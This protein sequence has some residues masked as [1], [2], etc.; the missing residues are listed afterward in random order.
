MKGPIDL[1][2]LKQLMDKYEVVSVVISARVSEL[3]LAG[4]PTVLEK[5]L[6]KGNKWL[7]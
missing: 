4:G 6:V 3:G 5:E 2:P 1:A 7:S